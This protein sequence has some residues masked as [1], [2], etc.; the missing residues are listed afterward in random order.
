MAKKIREIPCPVKGLLFDIK[1]R[2]NYL[3]IVVYE[4]NIMEFSE[5]QREQTM[6]Y[7]LLVRDLIMSYQVPCEIEG[8][9]YEREK[10]AGTRF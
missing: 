9:S 6:N 1:T 2:P 8:V 3:A 7:L 10:R 4:S 5:S